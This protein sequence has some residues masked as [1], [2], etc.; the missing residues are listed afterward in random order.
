M[1]DFSRREF[2]K[3]I[4]L[5]PKKSFSIDSKWELVKLGDIATI[6]AGQSPNSDFYNEDERGLP[7]FQGKKD[8]G[9]IF[10]NLPHIWTTQITKESEK[11]DLLMSV[12][13]PVGDVN[14]NPFEKFVSVEGWL[15]SGQKIQPHKNFFLNL[16]QST[17]T[18]FKVILVQHLIQFQ[19]RIWE[20]ERSPFLPLT[21]KR[22]L[23]LNAKPWTKK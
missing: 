17:R 11:N 6:I 4:S 21:S 22:K 3:A 1:L 2:N 5:T 10:L 14:L 16:Y 9:K 20:K 12:R 19:Q 7:F 23:S 13:A 18:C 15:P 8:F